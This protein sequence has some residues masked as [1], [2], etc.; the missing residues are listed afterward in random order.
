MDNR[1]LVEASDA[2]LSELDDFGVFDMARIE[3]VVE[4]IS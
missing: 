3:L 2:W 4:P 1:G